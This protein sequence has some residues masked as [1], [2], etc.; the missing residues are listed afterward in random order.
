[1][2]D[3][4][5]PRRTNAGMLAGTYILGAMLAFALVGLLVGA[6]V[7]AVALCIVAGVLIGFFVGIWRVYV[8]FR[9]L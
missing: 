3:P 6:L 5:P 1:M 9:D 7:G 8:E 4:S 2:P